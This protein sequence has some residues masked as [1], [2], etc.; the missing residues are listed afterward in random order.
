MDRAVATHEARVDRDLSATARTLGC[1]RAE[2]SKIWYRTEW[3]AADF[4]AAVD[5]GWTP[6]HQRPAMLSEEV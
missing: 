3:T 2:V 5:I 6:T 1:S 4:R